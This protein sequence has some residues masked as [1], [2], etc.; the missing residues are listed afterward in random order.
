[1]LNRKFTFFCL[2][3]LAISTGF[4]GS[5]FIVEYVTLVKFIITL[6]F[7]VTLTLSLLYIR[8]PHCGRRSLK[9]NPFAKNA[10]YCSRCGKLVEFDP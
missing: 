6:S 5:M 9:V 1:M 2:I 8:C 3:S 7:I 10:G 4:L